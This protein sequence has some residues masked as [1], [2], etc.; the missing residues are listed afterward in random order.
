MTTGRRRNDETAKTMRTV[1][2]PEAKRKP[3]HNAGE[4]GK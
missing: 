2:E 4:D 1:H 3:E